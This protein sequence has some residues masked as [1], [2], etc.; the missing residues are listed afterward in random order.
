MG[1]MRR[2]RFVSRRGVVAVV[3]AV[4]LVAACV[5]GWRLVRSLQYRAAVRVAA[6]VR[7]SATAAVA[8]DVGVCDL[9][10]AGVIESIAGRQINNF[11]MYRSNNKL[12]CLVYFQERKPLHYIDITYKNGPIGKSIK[13]SWSR[14]FEEVAARDGVTALTIEGLEGRGL[15]IA[16]DNGA[17]SAVWEYPDGHYA[18][19]RPSILGTSTPQ[20]TA[21]ATDTVIA[22]LTRVAPRL[23]AV[24]ALPEVHDFSY[25]QDPPE[26][27][28]RATT[29]ASRHRPIAIAAA[30]LA[31]VCA[32]G[33]YRLIRTRRRRTAATHT[34][35]ADPSEPRPP[36]S[37]PTSRTPATHS[38]P[39]SGATNSHTASQNDFVKSPL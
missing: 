15:L 8:D 28:R 23:P 1:W 27:D 37:A 25:P 3:V 11:W 6:S 19:V 5:G 20:D 31:T 32:A 29:T 30:A 2:M 38:R 39:S 9:V 12:M 7:A 17:P 35:P 36:D 18:A 21:A 24:A 10:P 4:G 14:S 16:D 34:A 22:V 33:G 26:A 13:S